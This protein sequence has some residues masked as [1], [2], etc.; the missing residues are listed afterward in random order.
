MTTAGNVLALMGAALALLGGLVT[1][2]GLLRVWRRNS[3]QY[4]PSGAAFGTYG[5]VGAAAGT[6]PVIS[7]N[8]PVG[9]PH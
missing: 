3:G 5:F 4:I 7:D 9:S 1:G 6:S 8:P 2:Y